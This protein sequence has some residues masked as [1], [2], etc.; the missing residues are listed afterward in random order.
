M[1]RET[2]DD[3]IVKPRV[4]RLLG[5]AIYALGIIVKRTANNGKINS[6]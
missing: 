6:I 4:M 2:L 1:I 5:K 3:I